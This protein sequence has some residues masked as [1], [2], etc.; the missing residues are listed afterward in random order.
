MINVN[1]KETSKALNRLENVENLY[2]YDNVK[3]SITLKSCDGVTDLEY[4]K[5]L[6][7]KT[8]ICF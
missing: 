6:L 5:N 1:P 2:L 8:D 7:A 3:R 4:I